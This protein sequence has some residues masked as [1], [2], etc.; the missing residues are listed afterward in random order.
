MWMMLSLHASK[1][2]D[3]GVSHMQNSSI[4][5]ENASGHV[6]AMLSVAQEILFYS[7]VLQASQQATQKGC[8]FA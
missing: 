4:A 8:A 7:T 2:R 6:N 3:F 5:S 1:N